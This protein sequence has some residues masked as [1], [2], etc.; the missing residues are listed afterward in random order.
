MNYC[1]REK[2][3]I[4]F[5]LISAFQVH[6]LSSY[7][8]PCLSFVC[9]SSRYGDIWPNL[10]IFQ[11]IQSNIWAQLYV[12]LVFQMYPSQRHNLLSSLELVIICICDIPLPTSLFALFFEICNFPNFL[13]CPKLSKIPPKKKSSFFWTFQKL[14]V[15]ITYI[16]WQGH[17]LY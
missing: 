12:I 10:H 1:K 3:V 13:K 16:I 6:W 15:H 4:R 8:F 17:V 11:Y 9:L 5:L 14:G 2:T 7:I